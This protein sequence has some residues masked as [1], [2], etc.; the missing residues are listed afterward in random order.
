MPLYSVQV[1][2]SAGVSFN[3]AF[4]AFTATIDTHK[5][6]IS[7]WNLLSSTVALAFG[8]SAPTSSAYNRIIIPSGGTTTKD[9]QYTF[10][11][12]GDNIYVSAPNT[13]IA[14]GILIVELW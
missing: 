2:A 8:P 3:T 7:V 11:N 1:T 4:S 14:S 13:A 9:S 5:Y 6:H 12:P 10:A